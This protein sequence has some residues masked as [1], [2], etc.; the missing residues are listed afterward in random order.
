VT[1]PPD[2]GSLDTAAET[3]APPPLSIIIPTLDEEHSL[4]GLLS[5][6][7]GLGIPHEVIV[8]DGGSID[9]TRAVAQ[10]RGARIIPARRGRGHQL[11][12]GARAAGGRILCFLHADVRLPARTREAIADEA[13]TMIEGA[14]VFTLTINAAGRRYRL[15]ER[16]ANWRSRV[17]GLP[18]GDQGLLVTRWDYDAVGGHPDIKLMEDVAI[19]RALRRHS[20]V[21]MLEESV[22]V[23]ARRWQRDGI[24]RRTLGNWILI[25]LYVMG[26]SPNFLARFYRAERRATRRTPA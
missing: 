23:S 24:W 2:P 19:V 5:D 8:V 26:F 4:A 25:T 12:T 18:Y 1:A 7:S 15:I 9:R 14:A 16:V 6:L 17:L 22:L 21:R 11:A 13:M 20:V 10:L 3:D